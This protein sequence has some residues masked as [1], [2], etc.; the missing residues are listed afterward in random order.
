MTYTKEQ[1]KAM[2]AAVTPERIEA[3]G[4]KQGLVASLILVIRELVAKV[5]E[6]EALGT[7]YNTCT[8]EKMAFAGRAV[9]CVSCG[10]PYEYVEAK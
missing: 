5:D 7:P 1:I 3:V 6:L 10:K 2:L 9:V 4:G 8:H